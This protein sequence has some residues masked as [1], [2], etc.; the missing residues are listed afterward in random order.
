MGRRA[1][2]LVETGWLAEH[3]HD[4]AVALAPRGSEGGRCLSVADYVRGPRATREASAAAACS[5]CLRSYVSGAV[6][7]V[8][9]AYMAG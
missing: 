5:C 1:D 6:F 9:G 4:P 7:T 2:L 8:D 3:L